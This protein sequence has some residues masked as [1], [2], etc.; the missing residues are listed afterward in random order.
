VAAE[1]EA[2]PAAEAASRAVTTSDQVGLG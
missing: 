1:A 2:P